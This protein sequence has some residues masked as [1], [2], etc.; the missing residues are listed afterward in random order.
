MNTEDMSRHTRVIYLNNKTLPR[1]MKSSGENWFGNTIFQ[2][3]NSHIQKH[4]M[5]KTKLYGQRQHSN[6]GNLV[7]EPGGKMMKKQSM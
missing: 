3:N 4:C 5:P 2:P 1:K 7:G 6:M